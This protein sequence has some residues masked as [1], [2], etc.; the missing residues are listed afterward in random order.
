MNSVWEA[1]VAVALVAI[2]VLVVVAL[3]RLAAIVRERGTAT[4]EAADL[5]ARLDTIAQSSAEHER[6]VRGDLAIARREQNETAAGL[7]G[8]VGERL[9]EVTKTIEQKLDG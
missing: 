6:D 2:L 1:V 5:R 9:A 4:R 3:F 7:R 8:E